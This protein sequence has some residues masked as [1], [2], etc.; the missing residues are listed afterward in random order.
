MLVN[1]TIPIRFVSGCRTAPDE[2][3]RRFTYLAANPFLLGR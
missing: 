1:G 2:S 3:D